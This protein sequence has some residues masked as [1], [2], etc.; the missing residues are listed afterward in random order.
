MP[1][2][3]HDIIFGI[4]IVVR[5]AEPEV[6]GVDSEVIPCGKG[7]VERSIDHIGF[8]FLTVDSCG[9]WKL[10]ELNPKLRSIITVRRCFNG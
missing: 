8:V 6:C 9:V 5:D 4:F 10:I 2:R 1:L 7:A 3:N